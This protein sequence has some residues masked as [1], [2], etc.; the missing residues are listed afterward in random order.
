MKAKIIGMF[1]SLT[2]FSVTASDLTVKDHYWDMFK[3]VEVGSNI[4]MKSVSIDDPS[5]SLGKR[6][7]K[8]KLEKRTFKIID[9]TKP[10]YIDAL[11]MDSMVTSHADWITRNASN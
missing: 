10:S 6:K 1:I 2:A 7:F 5:E 11:G 9:N 4:N 8:S 3:Q